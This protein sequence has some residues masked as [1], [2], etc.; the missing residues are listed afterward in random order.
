MKVHYIDGAWI[1]GEG[2]P[3]YSKDPMTNEIIWEG[4]QANHHEVDQ[5]VNAAKNASKKWSTTSLETRIHYINHFKTQLEKRKKELALC[6][7]KETGKPLWESHQE[8]NAMLGKIP[9]SIDAYHERSGEKEISNKLTLRHK[10]H[11]V[12]AIFGPYNFPAHLPNGHIIPALIA[13]NTIV[14]KSSEHT[15]TVSHEMM[16]CWQ[17]SKI[18]NGVINLVQGEATTGQ[19]LASNPSIDG[20]FFTGSAQV[21]TLLHS[22]FSAH[23]EKILALEMGGNNPL[24]VSHV[25]DIEAAALMTIQSAYITAG[26]RC[27]CAR[28]LIVIKNKKFIDTLIKMIATIE[29]GDFRN[30]PQPFF[31]PVVHQDV[32]KKLL[33]AQEQLIK[34][35]GSPLI[36]M[37]GIKEDTAL[38]SPGLIEMTGVE[39][40]PDEEYFGPLLQLYQVNT[41][42]EAISLANATQYGLSAGLLSSSEKE[43]KQFYNEVKAGVINWNQPTTGALSVAPF[44]GVKKSGNFRPSAYY[45]ADYCAYP[46]ASMQQNHISMPEDLPEGIRWTRSTLTH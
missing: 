15:P 41:M 21:G 26:Q 16:R 17:R 19:H 44:G 45:A 9:I 34:L 42:S 20:L 24:A 8:I 14:Y 10:P 27:S 29:V 32:K 39:H 43:F 28:R 7:S 25:D 30:T 35:G 11:G 36:L 40:V 6:I 2:D 18:P 3:F 33:A 1:E 12:I 37:K 38:L 31:G 4:K 23:P 5:A 13:G 22:Q 46:I